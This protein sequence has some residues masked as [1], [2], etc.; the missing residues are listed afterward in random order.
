M[1]Q[2]REFSDSPMK[3]STIIG[4]HVVNPKGAHL[5][6]IKEIV[7]DPRSGKVAYA[8]VAVGGF[9]GMGEKLIAVPFSTLEYSASRS[10][11][12]ESEYILH[13]SKERLESAPGF[14][15]EHW[16]LMS[17]EKWHRAVH[18][19]YKRIPYWEG[20]LYSN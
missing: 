1:N 4:T 8:V 5:G 2:L 9:L 13:I 10:D 20:D 19:Y 3:A 14:D 6:D 15:S 11:L 17:D 12:V 18:S 16:P 7:V